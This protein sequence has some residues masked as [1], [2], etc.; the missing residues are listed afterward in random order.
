MK[1][2]NCDFSLK[3]VYEISVLI[4]KTLNATSPFS[5]IRLGDGEG[6][7]LS[8]SEQSPEVD[9]KYL[10]KHLGPDNVNLEALLHLKQRLI[11]S[12]RGADTIGVRD[13]I[14]N[15]AFEPDDLSLPHGRFLEKFKGHFH[16][17]E[18][19]KTIDYAGARR[20]ALLHKNLGNLELR[21]DT[22]FCSAW[23]HYDYHISGELFKVLFQQE[24]VGLISCRSRL[25]ALLEDM[26]GVSVEFYE[27][28]DMYQN[29]SSDKVYPG[30]VE[31][32]EGLLNQKL[33]DA[34]GLLFLVG[35]GLYGKLYCELI[36]S[37][38]GIALDLGSLLDAWLGI[39]S[40]PAVYRSKFNMEASEAGVPSDLILTAENIDNLMKSR[41]ET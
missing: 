25:P 23:F 11:E 21:E 10:C 29:L 33:V 30:Y 19:E 17:R 12:V 31:K 15:V 27:I 22:R 4:S 35:G 38:G 18:V 1:N 24:R 41:S 36:K 13:D 40:R 16:L 9:F 34:P 2:P 7:L 14:V 8:I 32:L 37:Q 39:S 20:L 26:F 5:L 6:L 28:P 3:S